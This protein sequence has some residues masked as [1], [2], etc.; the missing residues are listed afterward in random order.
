MTSLAAPQN[1]S[2]R[3]TQARADGIPVDLPEPPAH[4]T[5]LLDVVGAGS[6]FDDARATPP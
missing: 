6:L 3:I 5:A 2:I 1:G 4:V